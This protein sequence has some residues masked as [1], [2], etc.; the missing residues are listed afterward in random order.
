MNLLRTPLFA[1][2][3][4]AGGKLI[5]FGGWEMPVYY[6]GI[7]EEHRAVR[8]RAGERFAKG[9]GS[10]G[11]GLGLAM[12]RAVAERHGRRVTLLVAPGM[13]VF[14]ALAQSAVQLRSGAI[15]VG[16]SEVMTPERQALLLGEAWD[17][18][19]HDMDLATRFVVLCKSGHV[20]RYSLGAH[21][22]DL[23]SQ[24]IDQIHRLWVDA[25]RAVGPDVHHRDIVSVAL[26]AMEDDL[27]GA[28]R[29][30]LLA[31]L[32]QYSAKAS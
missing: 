30:D 28:R 5:E 18:T 4:R 10:R 26:S 20:K 19:P 13:N 7:N 22:P 6:V 15:V 11:A 29:E 25:V 3:Q 16:E 2:H 8:A 12:A 24:D 31:R 17:R 27:S 32:R 14:D 9:R 21:T 23:S 1:A